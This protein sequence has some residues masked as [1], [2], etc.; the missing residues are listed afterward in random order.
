MNLVLIGCRA[1]G[2][3]TVGRRLSASL[4]KAFVDTDD[5]IEERQGIPIGDIVKI[6]G[7]DYFRTIERKIISEISNEDDLIIAAGGGAVL[8]PE[9][10]QALKRNGVII[11]L[12]AD[13]Q[14]LLQRMAN[15][16]RTITGRPSLTGKGTLK[17][18]EEVL[19][20]REPLYEMAS[21][22]QVNTSQLDMD[23]VVSEILS[24]FT[25]LESPTDCPVRSSAF[26]GACSGDEF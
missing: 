25:P 7:W 3:T 24:V 19:I 15:D 9:N 11:W 22:V 12:K 2:K 14:T 10:V 17:E 23:G 1:A 5:L 16:P 13:T 8:D 21:D 6:H 4:R 20:Q 18:F 26:I